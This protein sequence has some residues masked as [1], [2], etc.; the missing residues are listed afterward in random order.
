M[1]E[2]P[3]ADLVRTDPDHLQTYTLD[4]NTASRVVQDES[5]DRLAI[6]VGDSQQPD[7]K[8][9]IKILRWENEANLSIRAQEDASATVVT[10]GETIRYIA[11]DHEV[12]LYERADVDGGG[13]EME[14]LLPA[15]PR[16]NVFT[17]SLRSSGVAFHYQPE[18]TAEEIANGFRRPDNVIG[19]YAVYATGKRHNN[20]AH[21]KNYQLG[22]VAHIYRP[23]ATDDNG[24][25]AWCDLVI[26][27][28]AG[29]L[30][31]TVPQLFLDEAVYPV[32]VD[33]TL[34]YTSAGASDAQICVNASGSSN[35]HCYRRGIVV[36]MPSD[37]TLDS[38]HAYVKRD[39]DTGNVDVFMAVNELDSDGAD[40]HGVIFG[41]TTTFSIS[42]SYVLQTDAAGSESLTNANEYL[43]NI[44]ADKSS[45]G[46]NREVYVAYDS[47]TG[48]SNYYTDYGVTFDTSDPWNQAETGTTLLYSLYITYTGG[49]GGGGV[50]ASPK[51]LYP[52][53]VGGMGGVAIVP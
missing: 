22:K 25:Q 46:L 4:G 27:E 21:S 30:T 3:V 14:W 33:P 13:I 50:A 26:D 16:S 8:P 45:M 41:A 49:G 6:E 48:E 37:A 19:S 23:L 53:R 5:R 17:C 12:H 43:L 52:F 20:A 15:K 47:T 18:L 51:I 11:S 1:R 28:Q 35:D 44:E 2:Q 31:V 32:V 9:Q 34:G 42:T 36:T 29:T 10:E 7:F 40:S 24:V 39:I 38:V